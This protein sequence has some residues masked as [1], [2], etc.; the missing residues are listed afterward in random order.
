MRADVLS[1]F[2]SLVAIPFGALWSPF[3]FQDFLGR[4]LAIIPKPSTKS[5]LN[6]VAES[7]R[8][9]QIGNLLIA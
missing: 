1:C 5:V 9:A 6:G 8:S 2:R 7:S 3:C 4:A